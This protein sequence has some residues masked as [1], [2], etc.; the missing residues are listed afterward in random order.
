MIHVYYFSK[1]RRNVKNL[2]LGEKKKN[3]VTSFG[4]LGYKFS[5]LQPSV[6]K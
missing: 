6:R 4:G 2:R 3:F 1:K 5:K